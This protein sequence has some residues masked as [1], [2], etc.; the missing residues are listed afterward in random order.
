V[1]V[2]FAAAALEAAAE[3]AFEFV[4]A[5]ICIPFSVLLGAMRLAF[6]GFVLLRRGDLIGAS[7][8]LHFGA[9]VARCC[10]CG[11]FAFGTQTE[12]ALL[13]GV[14]SCSTTSTG[15]VAGTLLFSE[16]ILE[17]S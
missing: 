16:Q 15:H 13:F 10:W 7:V 14:C 6:A 12:S 9:D 5:T 8:R 3:F 4:F 17:L 2:P 1:E 11:P